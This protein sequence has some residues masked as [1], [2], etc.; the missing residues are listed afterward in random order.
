MWRQPGVWKAIAGLVVLVALAVRVAPLIAGGDRLERS[1]SEDGYLM[2][3]IARNLAIGKGFAVSDGLVATNGTQPLSTFLFAGLFWLVGGEKQAGLY[4]VVGFQVLVAAIGGWLV[5]RFVRRRFYRGPEAPIAAVLAG[6]L[7][8][9]SPTGIMHSQNGLE[10]GLYAVLILLVAGCYDRYMPRV[11]AG[12]AWGHCVLL[13]VLCGL[14]FLARNDACFLIAAL[15]VVHVWMGFREGRL[16]RAFG[17][18]FMIG[19]ISVVIA[20]PWLYYNVTRFGHLV[21]VSGRAVSAHVPF[22]HNL[23]ASVVALVENVSVVLRIPRSVQDEIWVKAASGV[24]LLALVGAL[25]VRWRWVAS[26]FSAGVAM[27][28]LAC[29]L[30]FAYYAQFFGA[31]HFLARYFFPAFTLAA[32]MGAGVI[33]PAA[34]RAVRSGKH[35]PVVALAGAVVFLCIGLDARYYL[36]GREHLHFQVVDWVRENVPTDQWVAAVQTGTLGYYKDRTINLDGKVDP[37]AYAAMREDRISEYV[38]EREVGYIVDWVGIS[39][40]VEQREDFARDWKVLIKDQAANL[41]V[42]ARK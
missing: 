8:F 34:V 21:P 11:Q 26:R 17:Q 18:A 33:A 14:T 9:S 15:I 31:P 4:L 16:I 13:G 10:T 24:V 32:V 3:T 1:I 40:W 6:V 23:S 5:Y 2:L 35:A 22:G 30:L 7:W 39:V 28:G 19:A 42:L 27:M 29:V 25:V 41:C 36:K 12:W 37:S 38:L 20:S